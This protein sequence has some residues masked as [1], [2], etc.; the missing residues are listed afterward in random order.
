MIRFALRCNE[1]GHAFEGWFR[2]NEDFDAQA[3]R[4]LLSCPVC[5]SAKVEKALMRPA[6]A[7]RAEREAPVAPVAAHGNGAPPEFVE[8]VRKMQDLARKVRAESDYVGR[9]F[10]AEARRIHYGET[11]ERR[12]Y[13]EA[14][15]DEVRSLL[16]EGIT[17]LPLPP[18][19]EDAN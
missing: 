2:S 3:A 7:H 16:D 12:I 13:G 19:P 17:A 9:G 14:S 6:V 15:G 8:M 4:D 10:A 1:A 5:G 18:L 11:E